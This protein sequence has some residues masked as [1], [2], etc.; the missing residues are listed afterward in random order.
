MPEVD[1]INEVM[2][3][4]GAKMLLDVNN[5]FVNG[6]NHGFSPKKFIRNLDLSRVAYIHTAGHFEDEESNM[7][8]DTHGAPVKNAVWRLLKDTLKQ[9]DVPVMLERDNNIPSLEE[10]EKEYTILSEIYHHART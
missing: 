4:S 3:Q 1:F 5:V 9:I 2:E 6:T 8:I 7:F 10:L